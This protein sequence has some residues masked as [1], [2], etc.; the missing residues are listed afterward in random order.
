MVQITQVEEFP[1]AT[2]GGGKRQSEE[3]TQIIANLLTGKSF[4]IADVGGDKKF[5][6]LQQKIRSAA[7]KAGI[8]VTISHHGDDLF[9]QDKDVYLAEKA[10]REAK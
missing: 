8:R 3:V 5:Q 6:A 1:T 4:K 10:A 9:F 2:R 7:N